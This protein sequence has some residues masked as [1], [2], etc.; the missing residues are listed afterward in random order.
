MLCVCLCAQYILRNMLPFVC[1]NATNAVWLSKSD[2]LKNKTAFSTR[3][4]LSSSSSSSKR[5][6]KYWIVCNATNWEI[7]NC[8]HIYGWSQWI[9][10]CI[11]HDDAFHLLFASFCCAVFFPLFSFSCWCGWCCQNW[12]SNYNNNHWIW[13]SK[14]Q[15]EKMNVPLC[16][17]AA[18]AVTAPAAGAA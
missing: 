15:W 7:C 6:R 8:A 9:Y 12:M 1:H 18:V 11:E 2:Q 3:W 4:S 17:L 10:L 14:R 5:R 13:A 16:H